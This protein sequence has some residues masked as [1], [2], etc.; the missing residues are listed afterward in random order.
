MAI[1]NRVLV[2]DFKR[3]EIERQWA[4]MTKANGRRQT[5]DIVNRQLCP[6]PTSPG[7]GGVIQ[8]RYNI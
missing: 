4:V 1:S 8:H 3:A 7:G 5:A 6:L 2:I